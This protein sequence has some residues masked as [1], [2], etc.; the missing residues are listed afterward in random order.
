MKCT[1]FSIK[2]I[3]EGRLSS[4]E[5]SK[6]LG[7][8][9]I[10]TYNCTLYSVT[11]CKNNFNLCTLPPSVANAYESCYEGSGLRSCSLSYSWTTALSPIINENISISMSNTNLSIK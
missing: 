9:I 2:T 1:K 3:E 7:G 10:C 8:D 6:L 4:V 5:M 11:E